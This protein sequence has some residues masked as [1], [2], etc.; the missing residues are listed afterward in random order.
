MARPDG[1]DLVLCA[2]LERARSSG[3][4]RVAGPGS[5]KLFL[6]HVLAPRPG[7]GAPPVIGDLLAFLGGTRLGVLRDTR[8]DDGPRILAEAAR[9]EGPS[10]AR[11]AV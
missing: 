5:W 9:L 6:D 2:A 1:F 11:G 4:R 8:P 7:P 10:S 3:F